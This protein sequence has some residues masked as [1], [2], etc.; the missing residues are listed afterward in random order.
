MAGIGEPEVRFTET[1]GYRIVFFIGFSAV[2]FSSSAIASK[3]LDAIV[4]AFCFYYWSF[5][6]WC[7]CVSRLYEC[8]H[9]GCIIKA[10]A[11]YFPYLHS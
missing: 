11:S 8:L 5:S 2:S 7:Q 10:V 9:L 4:D 6:F 3:A 1:N